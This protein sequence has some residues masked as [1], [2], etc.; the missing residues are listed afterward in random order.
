MGRGKEP[1]I[2]SGQASGGR[3]VVERSR[4]EAGNAFGVFHGGQGKW[5]GAG[6]RAILTICPLFCWHRIGHNWAFFGMSIKEHDWAPGQ[7][8]YWVFYWV[9]T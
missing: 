7:L 3:F 9:G 2:G 4:L 6:T 8:R 5:G 1:S